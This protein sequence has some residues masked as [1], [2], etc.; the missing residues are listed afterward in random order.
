M[1]SVISS[2]ALIA[3]NLMLWRFQVNQ[4]FMTTG[5]LLYEISKKAEIAEISVK[6]QAIEDIIHDIYINGV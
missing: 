2:V 3:I 1:F 6:E 4:G 5:H